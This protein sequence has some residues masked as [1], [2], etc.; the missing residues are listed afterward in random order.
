MTKIIPK[1]DTEQLM[2]ERLNELQANRQAI[3]DISGPIRENRNGLI[4]TFKRD[5]RKLA[6]D[7]KEAEKDLLEIDQQISLVARGLPGKRLSDA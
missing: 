1:K 2:R 6:E 5:E 4:A 3:L 7:I